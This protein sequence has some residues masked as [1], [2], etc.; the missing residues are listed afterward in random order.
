MTEPEERGVEYWT[1]RLLAEMPKQP[2]DWSGVRRM[3]DIYEAEVTM[4]ESYAFVEGFGYV[5][6][7]GW[8]GLQLN[9]VERRR[10][11]DRVAR[12]D[13]TPFGGRAG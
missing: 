1:S 10:L 4:P 7:G 6:V 5:A 12:R 11:R 13:R 2:D 9:P 8:L 3:V